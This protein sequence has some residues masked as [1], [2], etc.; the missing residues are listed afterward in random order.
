M[1]KYQITYARPAAADSAG[2]QREVEADRYRS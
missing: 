1:V 2:L